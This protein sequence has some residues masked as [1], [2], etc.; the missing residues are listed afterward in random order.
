MKKNT[1]KLFCAMLCVVLSI[2]LKSQNTSSVAIGTA[3]NT[4]SEKYPF[5]DFYNFSW[6][7]VIYLN[8]EIGHA[9]N[10]TQ[11][12]F[13]VNAGPT[14][15]T[16]ANQ[17]VLMRHTSAN[18]YTVANYP[19]E[20]GFTSVFNG[21]VT[22]NQAGA[23]GLQVI[24]LS[25][26]FAYNGTDNLEMLFENQ[27]GAYSTNNFPY[28]FVTSGYSTNRVRRDFNDASWASISST[29][30]CVNCAA[31]GNIPN[32]QLTMTCANTMTLSPTSATICNGNSTTLTA[33]GE[34]TYTWSPSTGLNTNT[35]ASVTAN[36]TSST[37]YTV[38]G[39][40]ASGCSQNLTLAV[41]VNA[42]PT[43][44]ISPASASI[45]NGG[46][47]TLTASGGSTYAWS[48]STGLN[49]T[50]GA[51][52]TAN[53]TST[54]T[55]T[56]TGTGSNGCTKSQT[57]VVTVNASPSITF[58]PASPAICKG[59]ST[60]VTA[61]GASSY[62]W[63]PSTGL[64]ATTGA[65]VTANP[66]ITTNYSVNATASNGCTASQTLAVTV[67]ALPTL[68][69]SPSSPS[70]CNGGGTTLTASG[71]NTYSWS[72]ATFLSAT[73]GAS[74]TASPTVATNYTLSGTDANSCVNTK[75]FSV[76]V[77]SNPSISI[78]PS[79]AVICNGSS[80]TLTAGGATMYTWS[81]STGLNTTSGTSVTANPSSTTTYTLNGTN[82]NGCAGTQTITVTVNSIPT[83]TVS[84][85]S[86]AI[87]IGNS[88]NITASG[89][90]TY[91]WSPATGLD[92]TNS[93][94]VT[95][96]PTS[97]TTYTIIGTNA[98]NCA[99][100]QLVT[101]TVNP[102]P[103][104]SINP[105][106]PIVMGG[107][108]PTI[109]ANG[110][111]TYTWSPSTNLS[112]TNGSTVTASPALATNYTVIGTSSSGCV[113]ALAFSV[114]VELWQQVADSGKAPIFYNGN[115]GI[116]T[117]T[118]IYPLDVN[119]TTRTK[120]LITDSIAP[121]NN[122]LVI[123]GNEKVNGNLSTTGTFTSTGAAT[124][125]NGL[126]VNGATTLSG[127]LSNTSFTG[128]GSR[129]LSTDS[130]GVI[131][132]LNDGAP[133]QVLF[134]NGTWGSL[135]GQVL[136]M[137]GNNTYFTGGNFGIGNNDPQF[138]LDVTGNARITGTLTAGG[139]SATSSNLDITT[140]AVFTS[141]VTL[142]S[143][144]TG[145]TDLS[146]VYVD[147]SGNLKVNPN[148]GGGAGSGITAVVPCATGNAPW[149]IGGNTLG[150]ITNAVIGTCD[151]KD[152][153]FEAY[154]QN[155]MWL[156]PSGN[157]GVGNSAPYKMLTVNGD[158]SFANY[159]TTGRG[160]FD[161]MSAIEILGADQ[162][163]TRRGITADNNPDGDLN[164]FIN[165]YQ[166][167]GTT[168]F[169]FKNGINS[170]NANYGTGAAAPN[171]M[172]ISD[173]GAVT[174]FGNNNNFSP[175]TIKNTISNTDIFKVAIDGSTLINSTST[176]N[177]PFTIKN[178]TGTPFE[179]KANGHVIINDDP[180]VPFFGPTAARFQ[181]NVTDNTLPFLITSKNASGNTSLFFVAPDGTTSIND[182]DPGSPNPLLILTHSGGGS[183]K[184][185]E[186]G[187]GD[188]YSSSNFR[189]T[190]EYG[191]DFT[192]LEGHSGSAQVRFQVIPGGG[193]IIQTNQGT[194]GT[195]NALAILNSPT[196]SGSG[197]AYYNGPIVFSVKDDGNITSAALAGGTSGTYRNLLV[198][199]NG[200]L[201]PSTA[202]SSTS[203]VAWVL[204]GNSGTI[205]GAGISQ[206]IGATD[207]TADLPFIT[208]NIE[209]MRI[210]STGNIAI[211]S[212]KQIL[213]NGQDVSHGVGIVSTSF[214]NYTVNGPILYG[215]S[216]GA[217][218]TN[219]SSSQGG[220][221][222]IALAWNETGQ[223]FVGPERPSSSYTTPYVF[224]VGGTMVAKEIWV[225]DQQ[226]AHWADYVFK[227]DYKLMPLAEVEKYINKNQHLPN[228]PSAK[229]VENK[230]QNL[231]DLQVKQMEKIEE[232]TL[233][234]IEVSKN[235][236]ELN[237]KVEALQKENEELK[238]KFK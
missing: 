184:F 137:S 41:T 234:M 72:P 15:L 10:I 214:G 7:N 3:T 229:E 28:F 103:S 18:G 101:L 177:S 150:T 12:A 224:S 104:I 111:S 129:L 108:G 217:L 169:N 19:G 36:P 188:I 94:S 221:S 149:R 212:G 187:V 227:K 199:A 179:V 170:S 114:G 127:A 21:S 191:G 218:G 122:G 13:Y 119:G 32:I 153:V 51:S 201:V 40:D 53:P 44:S 9:G 125:S 166:T 66:T 206:A 195:A 147:G 196:L 178:S 37:T 74:I 43:I 25:T 30:T 138:P 29:T 91:S 112:A 70:V 236:T 45:C 148:S 42:L 102:L 126:T 35:G 34:S 65:S 185:M 141:S 159:P 228:L 209:R 180:T 152:L 163:P 6:S 198:D 186:D 47:T 100:T 121:S 1:T 136:Q 165:T 211:Q 97:T 145:S 81:P 219:H 68:T 54:T 232:L 2:S 116:N 64:S 20:T 197:N 154:G 62:T 33:S 160:N 164:F 133:G 157:F 23:N 26:P 190:C 16:M 176:T 124:L 117:P 90:N 105:S 238:K 67:N 172:T 215:W 139:I 200:K 107:Q 118:P 73:T 189:P 98:N 156:K 58:S 144:A 210:L 174:I 22:Y 204:G 135:P 134:G 120:K 110:A 17:K 216:G 55:Y 130:Y 213:F 56:V 193:A 194:P 205:S 226:T 48:P 208:A 220:P 237:K 192:F 173:A 202:V 61:S 158:V 235:V 46:N 57:V 89:A 60:T 24:T 5:D 52:V 59:S 31:F 168:E 49:T 87:C 222:N 223:T 84:P 207:L 69:L 131:S 230:G 83:L 113:N 8:S 115:V 155:Y 146:E 106:V 80:T 77:N 88:T 76:A 171:L 143:L 27:N 123:T 182:N 85:S 82:A 142:S 11:I 167:T 38:T 161:G 71:A 79:S 109:T 39:R 99:G 50:T 93:A 203:S 140:P 128:N 86:P 132:P 162:V 225:L 175:L 233:Y 63:S 95:A 181:I 183:L 92:N 75:T 4:V 96:N 14:N 231:G 78:S 151:N